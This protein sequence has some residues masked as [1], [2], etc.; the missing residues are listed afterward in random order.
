MILPDKK[1]GLVVLFH[2]F[3]V[4]TLIS[5]RASTPDPQPEPAISSDGEPLYVRGAFNGWGASTPL[6]AQES[7]IYKAKLE[8]GLGIHAFKVASKDWSI[9]MLIKGG[10]VLDLENDVGQSFELLTQTVDYNSQILTPAPATFEL[11][12][13]QNQRPATLT[14]SKVEFKSVVLDAP[15]LGEPQAQLSYLGVDK[16][17]LNAQFSYQETEGGLRKYVHSTNQLLRD[18]VPQFSSYQEHSDQ[19][20]LRSGNVAF[21]ALFALA[22]DEMKLNSVANIQ[23]G[24]YNLGKAIE[25]ECFET[26]EKWNYVWTRDLSYAA[27]LGLGFFDPERVENSLRFK[28]APLRR[29]VRQ[30]LASD[31]VP[32]GLQ[33]VQDTGSGGSWPISTDRVTWAF[34]AESILANMPQNKRAEFVKAAFDALSNTIDVDRKAIFNASLGLYQGEQSFLDWREQTYANWIVD[35]LSSMA[36]SMSL[37]TNVGHFQTLTLAAQ[38]AAELN[39]SAIAKKYKSWAT[40][41]KKAINDVLWMPEHGMYSSLTSGHPYPVALEK[42]DWLGLALAIKT[43]IASEQQAQKILKNYPHSQMGPPVIFPQQPDIQIYHNRAIWP[44]VT[45]YGLQAAIVGNNAAVAENAIASLVRGAALNLSNMENLEWQSGQSIWLERGQ[46]SLSGPAINSKRQ[47]WS[48]AGYLNM[49]FSSVLGISTADENLILQPFIPANIANTYFLDSEQLSL[50]NVQWQDKRFNFTYLLPKQRPAGQVFKAAKVIVNGQRVSK[51]DNGHF[52]FERGELLTN[53][54]IVIELATTAAEDQMTMILGTLSSDD[55][56]HV[57]PVEPKLS[58]VR[59]EGNVELMIEHPAAGSSVLFDI[60]KDG[61][62]IAKGTEKTRWHLSTEHTDNGCYAVQARF[63]HSSLA[64]HHSQ[65]LCTGV[66]HELKLDELKLGHFELD[67]NITLSADEFGAQLNQFG[68]ATD[69]LTFTWQHPHSSRVAIQLRY[70]N[71]SQAINTGVTA[72][73]KRVEVKHN[74]TVHQHAVMQFP[75]TKRDEGTGLST[76]IYLDLKA[77]QVSLTLTD[78]LNMSYLKTNETYSSAGGIA[79]V[80]NQFDVYGLVITPLNN[81]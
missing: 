79:G 36:T 65:T 42:F 9:Q 21:D 78:Y 67:T 51:N 47:L 33:I 23:D 25:C 29:N 7:G 41:L 54:N 24:N 70:R 4:V 8:V 15:H 63:S 16:Q 71:L 40:A 50:F 45:A 17:P 38:L 12:L 11:I 3:V 6:I 22:I 19:P 20:Y 73:V 43:G 56:R 27:N 58:M 49:V 28:V 68:H 34:G 59:Q 44:F 72:G 37:S 69:H 52:R 60:F 35:D 1:L 39:K 81:E 46:P 76:P 31:I 5:C 32:Q 18:P 30:Q 62:L 13:N 66:S 10:H 55:A 14:L 80:K 48:V 75:H 53:N 77:G 26:G 57:A 61:Q 2:F 74:Q 64:S